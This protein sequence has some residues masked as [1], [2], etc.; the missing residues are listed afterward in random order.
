MEGLMLIGSRHRNWVPLTAL[1]IVLP[2]LA[3]F[4]LDRAA[5][6]G[7][8]S[9]KDI[10]F[11][12][13][14]SQAAKFIGYQRSIT[15][16]SEQKILR[17]RALSGI[18]APCCEKFSAATC[19][20]PCNLAKSIWGLSNYVIVERKGAEKEIQKS[21]RGWLTFINSKGFSGDACDAA[22]GCGRAFSQD[23]C[24]GMDEKNLIA[25]R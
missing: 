15:L 8:S 20:C 19:C 25:A 1:V 3:A 10:K 18:A 11:T 22:G 2:A 12:D 9:G 7:S 5:S 14:P 24:G 17:D 21:V 16:T 13:A 4:A 6:A 23:G